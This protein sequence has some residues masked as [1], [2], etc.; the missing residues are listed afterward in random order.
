MP[1]H[2]AASAGNTATA[3]RPGPIDGALPTLAETAAV[4]LPSITPFTEIFPHSEPRSLHQPAPLSHHA[5][6]GPAPLTEPLRHPHEV[7]HA[8]PSASPANAPPPQQQRA[9]AHGGG[10]GG[11]GGANSGN[12]S[13]HN[14]NGAAPRSRGRLKTER[15]QALNKAAQHRYRERKKAKALELEQAVA[16]LKDKVDEL[17][18]VQR[19]KEELQVRLR[20][21]ITGACACTW[22]CTTVLVMY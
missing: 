15:Q 13:E 19:E 9:A 2:V 11:G 17:S 3:S 16:C 21:E 6:V 4:P 20:A 22:L 7:S 1:T 8:A 14:N 10:G 12:S 18:V 5:D